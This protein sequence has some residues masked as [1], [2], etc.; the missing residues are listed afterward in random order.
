MAQNWRASSRKARREL[1]YRA[2]PL[3]ETLRETVDW[4]RELI[5][6]GVF[7]GRRPSA[8]SVGALG[9]RAAR[10]V[11]VIAAARELERLSGRRLVAGA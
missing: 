4:Y 9:M 10:R 8:M 3:E 6:R 2:R 7:A 11:G 1:G 5:D